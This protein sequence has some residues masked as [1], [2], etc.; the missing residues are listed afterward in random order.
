MRT[1]ISRAVFFLIFVA[2]ALSA[3]AEELVEKPVW[4]LKENHACYEF[5][6]QKKVMQ[7]RAHY[8]YLFRKAE[9]CAAARA[10]A[11]LAITSLEAA[12][13]ALQA[14]GDTLQTAF[15]DLAALYTKLDQ[16]HADTRRW[17][18]KGEALPWVIT[19]GVALLTAGLLIGALAL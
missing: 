9:L 18:L 12:N 13:A 3:H 14:R 1:W 17:S 7:M 10:Q 15:V 8:V 2:T 16:Q 11:D 4:Q 6:E 19:G 5:E